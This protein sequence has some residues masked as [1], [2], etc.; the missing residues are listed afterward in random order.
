[1]TTDTKIHTETVLDD[2]DII[3]TTQQDVASVINTAK[4][5]IETVVE[6]F[7]TNNNEN[8]NVIID[9]NQETTLTDSFH[10]VLTNTQR[11]E[12]GS[13]IDKINT[14]E[15][16]FITSDK[17]QLELIST[18]INTNDEALVLNSLSDKITKNKEVNEEPQTQL[19]V[20]FDD[21]LEQSAI[22]SGRPQNPLIS[23]LKDSGSLEL[24][25]S[26]EDKLAK[27]FQTQTSEEAPPKKSE[28]EIFAQPT[29][30]VN[31]NDLNDSLIEKDV[32][33]IPTQRIVPKRNTKKNSEAFK[34]GNEEDDDL[35]F[36]PTQI[37]AN[38][39]E[40]APSTAEPQEADEDIFA[41][42]TQVL[43]DTPDI[44]VPISKKNINVD[45]VE[46]DV[47]LQPTQIVTDTSE[48]TEDVTNNVRKS[49]SLSTGKEAAI[50]KSTENLEDDIFL[51]STQIV[52]VKS[53]ESS[54]RSNVLENNVSIDANIQ[55]VS[56]TKDCY[57]DVETYGKKDSALSK[58]KGENSNTAKLENM[59]ILKNDVPLKQKDPTA[60]TDGA[61]MHDVNVKKGYHKEEELAMEIDNNNIDKNILP[62]V[63]CIYV[64]NEE[65][66]NEKTKS[67]V[68]IAADASEDTSKR[69]QTKQLVPDSENKKTKKQK[70]EN[71]DNSEVNTSK[72]KKIPT[73]SALA[74]S[75]NESRPLRRTRR[76][77]SNDEK[78]EVAETDLQV[79]ILP[80]IQETPLL[81]D[82][83]IIP[84]NNQH[85]EVN[86]H[87]SENSEDEFVDTKLQT[88]LRTRRTGRQ[89]S[90][91]KNKKTKHST[92]T[93][94]L[95]INDQVI[96]SGS[97]TKRKSPDIEIGNSKIASEGEISESNVQNV[98]TPIKKRKVQ[99]RVIKTRKLSITER[100][101]Q[102]ED[103][104]VK[105]EPSSS[106]RGKTNVNNILFEPSTSSIP[107]ETVNNK[108]RTS[109]R[110]KN[111]S[112]AHA[113]DENSSDTNPDNSDIHEKHT[114]EDNNGRE[115]SE[116]SINT[117]IKTRKS[118]K[119]E[120]A[121]QETC[122]TSESSSEPTSLNASSSKTRKYTARKRKD[123]T[124]SN[125]S[126]VTVESTNSHMRKSRRRN[127]IT[128]SED[129]FEP[130][131]VKKEQIT[132]NATPSTPNVSLL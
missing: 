32:F 68:A 50:V 80:V 76:K 5:T 79:E 64:K 101:I 30:I 61:E 52:D 78:L 112:I 40:P 126:T 111:K 113:A 69:K 11:L 118:K 20:S 108:I 86:S 129:D 90:S 39:P 43:D 121:I 37:I 124:T 58:S 89:T 33:L 13:D 114:K 97:R 91:V 103:I 125:I 65:S 1:M 72:V 34:N 9:D 49:E 16:Q 25:D 42:P 7:Q 62:T 94:A 45:V 128:N 54:K 96:S 106:M 15:E 59:D 85:G 3:Q 27:M 19:E 117:T 35:F 44:N 23:V 104:E 17:Q 31:K 70:T 28:D 102:P 2:S 26:I 115:L 8:K 132:T 123:S 57:K 81:S 60:S 110:R 116:D 47:F 100:G 92:S 67:E 73:K 105:H 120:K 36:K 84:T 122:E 88:P 98:A 18:S 130:S 109:S 6:E 48:T 51:L 71:D 38:N 87:A 63:T 41:K 83:Q 119:A 95:A 12:D 14:K 24:D 66:V 131:A 10:L 77:N 53:D 127:S 21:N 93:N 107:S 82:A 56:R 74:V 75:I 4:D 99:Q 22:D 46:D 29:Q 55:Q